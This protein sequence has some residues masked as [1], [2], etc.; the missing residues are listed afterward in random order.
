MQKGQQQNF[1]G[2]IVKLKCEREIQCSIYLSVSIIALGISAWEEN[3]T[4]IFVYCDFICEML[5]DNWLQG[6]DFFTLT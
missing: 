2:K 1:S 6:E 3:C 5:S 4:N